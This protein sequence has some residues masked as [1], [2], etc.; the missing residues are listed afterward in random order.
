MIFS[1]FKSMEIKKNILADSYRSCF[2]YVR[3][4]DLLCISFQNR[5]NNGN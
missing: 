2:A 1:T 5:F 3:F 4:I